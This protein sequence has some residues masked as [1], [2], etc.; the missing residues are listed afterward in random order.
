MSKALSYYDWK[1][2]FKNNTVFEEQSDK[3]KINS[4]GVSDT[5]FKDFL[6]K[7]KDKNFS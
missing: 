5:Y 3:E 1:Q 2:S 4:L 6:Q 7:W